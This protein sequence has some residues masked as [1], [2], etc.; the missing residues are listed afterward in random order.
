MYQV[1]EMSHKEKVEMYTALPKEKLVEMLIECNKQ[2]QAFC[3][4]TVVSD[5]CARNDIQK[6]QQL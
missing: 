1:V 4:P 5:P 3:K 2:L 6:V